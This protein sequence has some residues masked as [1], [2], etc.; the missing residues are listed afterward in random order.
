MSDQP[1]PARDDRAARLAAALRD[2]LHKR[3]AR[4]RGVE[5]GEA[6]PAAPPSP[7]TP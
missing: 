6:A 1:P 2:N 4:A 7:D 3:K 5:A